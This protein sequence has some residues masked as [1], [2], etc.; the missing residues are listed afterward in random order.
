MPEDA[1]PSSLRL[2]PKQ[3]LAAQ[4]IADGV[5][6]TRA[7]AHPDIDVTKQTM[8][9]WCHDED[10]RARVDELRTDLDLQA[11]EILEGGQKNA[12]QTVVDVAKGAVL[13]DPKVLTAR[14]KA[15]LYILDFLKV[16]KLPPKNKENPAGSRRDVNKLNDDEVDDLMGRE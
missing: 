11:R 1:T 7:A 13:G 12:A 10:F 4:L 16:K 14:L 9:R 3:E 6:Q 8:N 15:A 5:S 2:P